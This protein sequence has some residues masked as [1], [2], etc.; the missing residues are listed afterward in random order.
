MLS[1]GL[2]GSNSTAHHSDALCYYGY[3]YYNPQLGRWPSRDPIGEDGGLNLYGF[4][5]NDGVN[6]TD[7]MGLAGDSVCDR[8]NEIVK[9]ADGKAVVKKLT[10]ADIEVALA[11][12]Q[13]LCCC[14]PIFKLLLDN[15][16]KNW[17]ENSIYLATEDAVKRVG[18]FTDNEIVKGMVT[19][20]G[21]VV[22]AASEKT[23]LT[24]AHELVH[25]AQGQENVDP[26][27]QK[28]LA[29]A[30]NSKEELDRD[31]SD[32]IARRIERMIANE[33]VINCNYFIPS[34]D[35]ANNRKVPNLQP[36][37]LPNVNSPVRE[38]PAK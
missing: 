1:S 37:V 21:N 22:A 11:D 24:V 8:I 36:Q 18:G 2:L 12:L 7:L 3:R 31:E 29:S 4:V 32:F 27:L 30:K 28:V 6:R 10:G 17:P 9:N 5:G 23:P 26:S 15:F 16:D 13:R 25:M 35:I 14:S 34:L 20:K 19:E 33:A 38:E